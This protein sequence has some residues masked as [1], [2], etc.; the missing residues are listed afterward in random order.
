MI[1]QPILE[2]S[3]IHGLG[4]R[5]S[6]GGLLNLVFEDE[7]TGINVSIVDNGVGR[8]RSREINSRRYNKPKSLSTSI[9]QERMQIFNNFK[10]EKI[11]IQYK[12][13]YDGD[14]NGAGTHVTVKF[15]NQL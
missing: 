13:L 2:N 1:L 11:D 8:A 3:I 15:K 14:N 12:D 9:T 7:G 10:D 6:T 4:H 5:S